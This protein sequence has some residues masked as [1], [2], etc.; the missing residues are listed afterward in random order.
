MSKTQNGYTVKYKSE[1]YSYCQMKSRCLN[2]NHDHYR[3]YGGRG[4]TICERWLNSFIHFIDDMGAKPSKGYSLERRQTNGNYE[5]DNCKW[6]TL[7][8]QSNNTTKSL[9]LEYNGDRLTMAQ[10]ARKIGINRQTLHERFKRGYSTEQII[11]KSINNK[12]HLLK[13]KYKNHEKND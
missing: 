2:P 3:N 6:A 7:E 11:E 13:R 8:E 1:Y 5:P 12:T 4:I 10:W 9:F